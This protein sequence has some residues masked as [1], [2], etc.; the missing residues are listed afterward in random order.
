MP[1]IVDHDEYRKEMLD[2]CF[3]LFSTRG[4]AN[5]TMREIARELGI[6]TGSLYHYFSNKQTILQKMI[7]KIADEE[8]TSILDI[9]YRTEDISIRVTSFLDYFTKKE[10]YYRKLLL[11]IHDF[12]R[13]CYSHDNQVFISDY[14]QSIINHV[15]DGVGVGK[16]F[17]I[18]VFSY[19]TGLTLL[20]Q[21]T[22]GVV[23]VAQQMDIARRMAL[24]YLKAESVL[25]A[26]DGP[27]ES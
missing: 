21:A 5:V 19:L 26:Q 12:M 15:A 20:L 27:K 2:K 22:P 4:Y 14:A 18:I 17:G 24:D 25:M 6:S 10:G 9:V 1:K 7:E 16:N 13:F 3:D 8:I 23:D 11:L